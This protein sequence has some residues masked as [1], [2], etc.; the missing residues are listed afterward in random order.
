MRKHLSKNAKAFLLQHSYIFLASY[1]TNTFTTLLYFL[2]A[3][4]YHSK[5]GY[6]KSTWLY[7]ATPIIFAI[8]S[9]N[10]NFRAFSDVFVP[11]KRRPVQDNAIGK[12]GKYAVTAQTGPGSTDLPNQ[13]SVPAI[14]GRLWIQASDFLPNPVHIIFLSGTGIIL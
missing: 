9:K 13:S 3:G 1:N 6:P 10:D 5:W 4:Y 12:N 11:R 7:R 2:T 14:S 8:I